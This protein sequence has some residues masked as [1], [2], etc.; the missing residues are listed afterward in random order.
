[1]R[2]SRNVIRCTWEDLAVK[3]FGTD[4]DQLNQLSKQISTVLQRIKG[5]RRC[6]DFGKFGVQYQELRIRRDMAVRNQLDSPKHT[7]T[8]QNAH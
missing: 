8:T 1:M 5:S 4:L 7:G 6:H 3:I 2:T